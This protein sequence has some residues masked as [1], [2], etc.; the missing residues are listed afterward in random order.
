MIKLVIKEKIQDST[1]TKNWKACITFKLKFKNLKV[2]N[3]D[4][5]IKYR[6]NDFLKV[7]M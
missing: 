4:L 6:I 5:L 7:K 1:S 2:N 3:Q